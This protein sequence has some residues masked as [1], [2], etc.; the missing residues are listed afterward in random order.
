MKE[1]YYEDV[2]VGYDLPVL[3]KTITR[4]QILEYADAGGDYNPIHVNEEYGRKAGLGGVIAHGLLSFAFAT[5]LMTDWLPD[6]MNLRKINVRFIGMVKPG[7]TLTIKGKVT[8]KYV[9]DSRN[10]VDCEVVSE[11]QKGEKSI[12]G[13]A[14]VILPSKTG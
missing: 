5:Q 8:G 13:K 11:N 6:P 4:E 12:I 1:I 3:E 7:D 10:C 2:D 14:T 9:K